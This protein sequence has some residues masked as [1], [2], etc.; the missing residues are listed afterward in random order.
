M[1]SRSICSQGLIAWFEQQLLLDQCAAGSLRNCVIELATSLAGA[2]F[3]RTTV[4]LR[5]SMSPSSSR[6][7]S[8]STTFRSPSEPEAMML[9]VRTSTAKRRGTRELSPVAAADSNC[10]WLSPNSPAAEEPAGR[11]N[12]GGHRLAE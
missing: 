4:S 9:F 10:G 11:A 8:D 12:S 1:I 5:V 2:F 3:S 6:R 7:S